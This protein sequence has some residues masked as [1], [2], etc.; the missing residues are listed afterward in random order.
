[1]DKEY[2]VT[3]YRQEDLEQFYNEMKLTN[4]P[5]V[6]KRPMSRNT[7]YMMTDEQAERLRQDPRVWGVEAVDNFQIARQVL[8][9]EPY[10]KS[11]NFWKDDTVGPAT[12]SPNDFQWG[13]VHCAGDIA[14][15]G[16]G[17]FGPESAGW[18]YEQTNTSIEVFNSGRHVDVVI[19]DDPI[20]YDSEEWYS[21]SS[22][23]TRFVQYQWFNELNT[24][25]N[26][27][28]DDNQTEPTGTINYHTNDQLP[29]YHGNHVCGTVAGQHYGW[30]REANIYNLAVTGSWASGQSVGAY[31]I[32]DYLRAF[33]RSKSVNPETG[34][35]NPTITNHSYGGI[36]YMPNQQ[37]LSFNDI[38]AITYQGVTY[39]ASNPGPSGWTQQGVNDDFGVRSGGGAYDVYPSYSAAINADVQDCIAEGIVVIGAAGNDNLLMA[40]VGDEN[41]NNTMSVSN[42]G[43]FYY[44]RGAW[45]NSPD[46]GA[47][48]VGAL[49]KQGDFR[50]STY[51]QF[52]PGI[53]VFAP[54][55]NILSAYNSNGLNDTKYSQGSANYFYPIQGTSM[56]SPQVCGIIACLA[57]G[58]ERIN[59]EF[60]RTYLDKFS[61]TGDMT[62]D[63]GGGGFDDGTCRQGSPN[64]YLHIENPRPIIG[65]IDPQ[66]GR[67][68]EGM[69]MAYPRRKSYFTT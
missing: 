33:H 6:M 7:H 49:S 28:D 50:R 55:D 4:F 68:K 29:Y 30:A 60:A 13:H 10:A 27:I 39:S 34:T 57:S 64:T 67:R 26:T 24:L 17:Q 31:L 11:G 61:I 44:N 63:I 38:T 25:V 18:S 46:S 42:V 40:D 21:P 23:Q 8:N 48:T 15:R 62:F 5:L 43:T 14:Q 37:P 58:K 35:K 54:G 2:I 3:L 19:V 32:F 36:I 47:I 41:W 12:V 1:M 51:T 65:F 16:K 45:P 53:D 59:N 9:N 22:N 66:V 56:A 52:G 20:S 69:G